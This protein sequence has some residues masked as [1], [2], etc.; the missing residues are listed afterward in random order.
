MCILS[1][2][3][4]II[5]R[6]TDGYISLFLSLLVILFFSPLSIQKLCFFQREYGSCFAKR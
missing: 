4:M 6:K 2:T 3:G 1:Y 5:G